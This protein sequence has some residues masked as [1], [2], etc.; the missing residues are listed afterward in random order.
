MRQIGFSHGDLFKIHDVYTKKNIELLKACG[1]NAIEINCHHA[2]E[3]KLLDSI[4]PFIKNF[5]YVSLHVPCDIRYGNNPETRTLLSKLENF[6]I[7]TSACLAVIHPDLVDDWDVFGDYNINWAIENMD[8]RKKEFKNV[9]SLK[10]FFTSYPSW[11]LV[12]D[13]GHCNDNDKSMLLAKNIILEFKGRIKEIHLSG[14]EVFHDPL[15]RTKQIEI[16]DCCKLL[17]VPII[18]ESAFEVI[19]GTEGI[20]KEMD[21]IIENLKQAS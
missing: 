11:S 18:I 12:L 15:Y 16:I 1:S 7:K 3:T 6:Y 5:D 2:R 19:D 20:K 10:G 4:L 13:V 9:S 8:T 17:D 14:Y 21:Y